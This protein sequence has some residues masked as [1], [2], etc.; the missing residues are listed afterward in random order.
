MAR[1]FT[2]FLGAVLAMFV[3]VSANALTFRVTY[4][5]GF[6]GPFTGRVVV[7]LSKTASEPRFGPNWFRPEPMVSKQFKGVKPGQTM[8]IS[9]DGVSFPG[10]L[11]KIETGEYNVQAVVDRNLG[12][13]TIAGSPGNVFSKTIRTNVTTTST[14]DLFCDQVVPDRKFVETDNVKEARVQS[15]LLTQF[16]K[17]PTAIFGAVILPP[18][19]ATSPE[20]RYPV[21]YIIPGFGGDSMSYSGSTRTSGSV[22]GDVEFIQVILDPNCPTGH[23]VFADSA[24]NGPWGKALTTELIPAIDKRF[25]TVADSGARYVNGHSSGGWSSLWLQVT[26]PDVF[27][28]TWSTSP[29][30]VDFRDFQRIDLY[31]KNANMFVNEK[32]APRPLARNGDTPIVFYKAFSDMERPIRGE[33]LGSF[34]AVF[35][36]RGKDGQPMPL[37]N[38]D[39]G[40]VD[41]VVAKAWQKYDIGLIL[42][43]NWKTLGPKLKG[44]LHVFTGDIDTFYLEGAVR[45]LKADM[46]KLG[47]DAQIEIWPGDHGSV[48]TAALRNKIDQEMADQFHAW[49]R[50][51]GSR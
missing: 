3:A 7:Y 9:G 31:A 5:G 34:D 30:P 47:S 44:K 24:N 4:G 37:W 36:P 25:R 40:N 11:S 23:S 46:E 45:L 6:K 27:G 39:N 49:E 29:D 33:Q 12:G 42:R 15:A 13:R 21:L 41:P 1:S 32:G 20:R 2:R 22:R 26:Y 10:D 35:S 14:I 8:E 43:N 51:K 16:Y 48:M 50:T 38:R 18:S 28:G 19:Y 17:R